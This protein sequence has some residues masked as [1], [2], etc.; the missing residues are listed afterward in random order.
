MKIGFISDIHEDALRLK[1]A[2]GILE[3]SCNKI[4]CLGDIVGY[5][6][7]YY[8]F[9][10]SRNAHECVQIVKDHCDIAV[11]GN[12]D[13]A[14]IG[15]LPEHRAGIIYPRNFYKI[16]L[17]ERVGLARKFG[18][19]GYENDLPALMDKEDIR[20]LRNLPEQHVEKFDSIRV[21]ISHYGYPDFVGNLTKGMVGPED[22][23]SHLGY[24]S[25]NNCEVGISGHDHIEGM[26]IYNKNAGKVGFNIRAKIPENSWISCP[27]VAN[28]TF[29][30]G[31]AV[32]DT[33]KL[34]MTT[35]PLKT[36]RHSKP[37]W[38][39]R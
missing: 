6:V 7:P 4:V 11:I 24:L 12:H 1:E 10:A 28:G 17:L 27:C 19:W 3:G 22:V 26:M 29:A 35:I 13:L 39:L 20:F 23:A 31:V 9:L 8:G 36:R 32:L 16:G 37:A 14:A 25:K 5:S 2:I 34:E 33:E 30:N 18:V 38:R 15:K 21:L